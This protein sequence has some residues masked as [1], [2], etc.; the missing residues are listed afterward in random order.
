MNVEKHQK[1]SSYVI[2]DREKYVKSQALKGMFIWGGVGALTGASFGLLTALAAG[3]PGVP[4]VILAALMG[5][6]GFAAG[7]ATGLAVYRNQAIKKPRE[8]TEEKTYLKK[9]LLK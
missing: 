9:T 6:L 1:R 2:Y 3:A 7:G 4:I 8:F 5:G